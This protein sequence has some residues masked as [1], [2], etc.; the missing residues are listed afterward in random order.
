MDGFPALARARSLIEVERY[1]AALEALAPAL[2]DPATEGEAWCLRTQAL[3]GMDDLRQALPAAQRAVSVRP[4]DEWPHRLLALVLMRQGK[5][6]G[7]LSAAQRAAHIA[8]QQVET[9]HVLAVCQANRRKKREAR[10]TADAVLELH[11]E[12]ALAHQTAGI[13]AMTS[14]KWAAAERHLR[15]SLRLQPEDAQVAAT[16]AEALRHQGRRAEAAEMLLVAGRTDPTDHSIRRSLGR[17][18][19]PVVAIGGITLVK[20]LALSVF[21]QLARALTHLR[22]AVAVGVIAV[23][24]ALV[25]GY[26]SYARVRGTRGLPEQVHRGLMPDHRNYALGWLGCAGLVSLPLAVWAVAAPPGHGRSLPLSLGL[27]LF[28]ALALVVVRRFW[29]GPFPN[30][31]PAATAWL[32]RRRTPRRS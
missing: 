28:S 22:P 8:P 31:L 1:D 23:S 26:L 24:F 16:L 9:L 7:A 5:R 6:K 12:A 11:P 4:E 25:G 15:E 27:L 14:R 3:I 19:L 10:E 21:A 18:G 20:G 2:G 13:V 30:P 32:A 29:T 17:V